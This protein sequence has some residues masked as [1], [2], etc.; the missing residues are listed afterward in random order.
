VTDWHMQAACR[1]RLA[2]SGY[3]S[4]HLQALSQAL[5]RRGIR[6]LGWLGPCSLQLL[7]QTRV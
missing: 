5:T 4:T 7:C 6:Y 1:A 2:N 3:W